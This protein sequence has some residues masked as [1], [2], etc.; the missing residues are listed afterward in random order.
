[1]GGPYTIGARERAMIAESEPTWLV[2]QSARAVSRRYT[3]RVREKPHLASAEPTIAATTMDEPA[4]IAKAPIVRKTATKSTPNVR[5]RR[6]AQLDHNSI[7]GKENIVPSTEHPSVQAYHQ[8]MPDSVFHS[9]QPTLADRIK[10][11]SRR[12]TTPTRSE[13]GTIMAQAHDTID[14]SELDLDSISLRR[15]SSATHRSQPSSPVV[16]AS[17]AR[18]PL[19]PVDLATDPAVN[20]QAGSV[21]APA[22]ALPAIAV[23]TTAPSIPDSTVP[24]IDPALQSSTPQTVSAR[25][26]KTASNSRKRKGD[27]ITPSTPSKRRKLMALKKDK[28]DQLP[29]R[30]KAVPSAPSLSQRAQCKQPL[31]EV[32]NSSDMIRST[33]SIVRAVW[34]QM[35]VSK[36]RNLSDYSN[37]SRPQKRISLSATANHSQTTS[38]CST[39]ATDPM[40]VPPPGERSPMPDVLG[41]LSYAA[42]MR[43]VLHGKADYKT[44][45][46]GRR[47]ARR[48]LQLLEVAVPASEAEALFATPSRAAA[49]VSPGVF[50][51]G[52]IITEAQQPLPLQS[53]D[54]FLAEFYDD[55]LTIEVQDASI[56]CDSK[57]FHTAKAVT[58]GAVKHRLANPA[59]TK[60]WNCL[61]LATHVEDGLRPPFLNGEDCRLLSKVKFPTASD[62]GDR[63]SRHRYD[64]GYKEVEKWALLAQK[65][66]LTEPH[67][68]SHGYSTYITVNQGEIGFGWLS[69]PTDEERTAWCA[70]PV[71]FIDGRWRYVVL[72]S[73]QTIYFPAGTVHFVFRLP[74]VGNTLCFGGHVLRCSNLVHWVKTLTQEVHNKEVT[75]EDI[76]LSAPGYLNR[77]ERFVRQ[78]EKM[79]Q[80]DKWG[81]KDEVDEFLKL[82]KKF[83]AL[84][85]VDA[86]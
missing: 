34:S 44:D 43:K 39:P 68:D 65:G 77:V 7:E 69:F 11:G 30:K 38:E 76:S 45:Y 33:E 41:Y 23:P 26:E 72:N 31:R 10:S 82:K 75:N 42:K 64:D 81:G 67:Q 3:T 25:S 47:Q 70:D 54:Q 74:A 12:R 61:E 15:P 14:I 9:D 66:A 73:G 78:A 28:T 56:R 63:A 22:R 55:N 57:S 52:P 51:N 80:L 21:A 37:D 35:S 83:M 4:T 53:V 40:D 58:V 85:D 2:N 19:K 71:G 16:A 79:G 24:G 8:N 1:M 36:K 32:T 62:R 86:N 20:G 17:D 59:K 6:A 29:A 50:F 5:T 13:E 48:I 49:Y 60:P 46:L 84:L 27:D 18:V